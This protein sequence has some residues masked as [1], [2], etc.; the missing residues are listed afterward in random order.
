MANDPEKQINE[1]PFSLPAENLKLVL[2][3]YCRISLIVKAAH[4]VS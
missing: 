1:S 3:T 4:S 2:R